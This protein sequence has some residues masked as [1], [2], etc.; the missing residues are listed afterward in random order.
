M[1]NKNAKTTFFLFDWL[2]LGRSWLLLGHS[3]TALGCSWAALGRSW[4]ALGVLLGA[5]GPLLAGQR[6]KVTKGSRELCPGSSMQ[7][8]GPGDFFFTIFEHSIAF[9]SISY[10]IRVSIGG[11]GVISL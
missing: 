3:W 9:H 4:G 7:G 11:W 1:F 5:L 2:L 8:R 6:G 10:Y